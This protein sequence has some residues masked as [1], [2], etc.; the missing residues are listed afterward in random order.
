MKDITGKEVSFQDA[1]KKNGIL[2]MFS[3]NTCPVVKKYQTRT[4]EVCKYAMSKDIGVVLLNP[5][6][7]TRDDGDSYGDMQ[8]YGKANNYSWYYV[9]R[10]QPWPMLLEL[11]G[12]Q[13]YY[14]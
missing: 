2:V 5:N 14:I 12:R 7:A 13:K 1:T 10:I 6:E 8:N 11:P 9:V 4:N 3:C